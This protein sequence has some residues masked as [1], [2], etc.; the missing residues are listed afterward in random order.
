MADNYRPR[1]E[2][3][4]TLPKEAGEMAKR[5]F[6]AIDGMAELP[7][8][9]SNCDYPAELVPF[10]SA[11]QESPDGMEC[12]P[13][14]HEDGAFTVVCENQY[15]EYDVT[16]VMHEIMK[17][18]NVEGV[19]QIE[20]SDHVSGGVFVASAKGHDGM[21]TSMMMQACE[22]RLTGEQMAIKD[23]SPVQHAVVLASLR[24]MQEA[25]DNG[26]VSNEL[27]S[28]ISGADPDASITSADIDQLIEQHVN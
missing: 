10:L 25:L 26:T 1:I 19:A 13:Q 2:I 3:D 17:A 24:M 22:R 11:M 28:I 5:V 12:I 16:L 14:Y 7:T 27:L 21:D 18:F 6:E 8:D 4:A 23:V 9:W 20:Y 15:R